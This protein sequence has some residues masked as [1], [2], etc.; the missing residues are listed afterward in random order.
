MCCI[1]DEE[2][3]ALTHI[4]SFEEVQGAL[5]SLREDKA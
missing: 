2:S 4:V 5:W 1:S 3:E